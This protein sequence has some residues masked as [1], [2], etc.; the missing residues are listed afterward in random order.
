MN[1]LGRIRFDMANHGL[2]FTR[3]LLSLVG[4][5]PYFV[6][7]GNQRRLDKRL[8]TQRIGNL[9]LSLTVHAAHSPLG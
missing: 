4:K 5:R 9:G 1:R 2:D 6:G 7:S 8:H 3:R